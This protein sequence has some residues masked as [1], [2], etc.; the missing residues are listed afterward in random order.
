MLWI[1]AYTDKI[2]SHLAIG[3]AVSLTYAALEARLALERVCYERLRLSHKYISAD[4]LRGWT[5]RYVVQTVMEMVDPKIASEW[6]LHIS[7]K[8]A[9]EGVP[10]EGDSIEYVPLGTQ[11]GF[12]PAQIN[13]LWQT[14]SSFLHSPKPKNAEMQ[15]DHYGSEEKI[16]PKIEEVLKEL[17]RLAQGTLTGA[18]VLKQVSFECVCGQH[19]VRS[20]LGLQHDSII[21]CIHENCKEQY[22]VEKREEDFLFERRMF[23]VK[24]HKCSAQDRL[25][26]RHVY[27]MAKEQKTSFQ[28][29]ECGEENTFMWR[30]MQV[31]RKEP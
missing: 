10:P 16:K 19:N 12:D 3:D 7:T 9:V 21:N 25:P 18:M 29:G 27:E 15:I 5:P 11:K 20:E 14:M 28:C 17:D 8:P 6:T 24:C 1:E 22:R 2:R 13:K 23:H 31:K 26:Y 4:D 30:L